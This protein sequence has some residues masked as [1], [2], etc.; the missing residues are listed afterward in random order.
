VLLAPSRY[1]LIYG[2]PHASFLALF[3]SFL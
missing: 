2:I 3:F 1:S